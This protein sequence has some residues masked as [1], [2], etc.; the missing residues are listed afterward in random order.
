MKRFLTIAVI[1]TACVV[2]FTAPVYA[3]G[4]KSITT[5]VSGTALA[6]IITGL[7]AIGIIAKYTNWISNILL[8]VGF[9]LITIGNS[10]S[11]SKIT[12]EEL[13]D[14]KEKWNAVRKAVKDKPKK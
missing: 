14:M 2:L 7:L 11:D 1:F 9:L 3:F 5:W 10:T 4:W 13:K 6:F 8:A 12:K